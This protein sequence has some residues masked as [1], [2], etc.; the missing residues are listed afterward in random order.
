MGKYNSVAFENAFTTQYASRLAFYHTPG[1]LYDNTYAVVIAGGYP[2][3]TADKWAELAC[4]GQAREDAEA[5][6]HPI[7]QAGSLFASIKAYG[8]G[9]RPV[10]DANGGDSGIKLPRVAPGGWVQGG[11]WIEG[12]EVVDCRIVGIDL[13]TNPS[14]ITGSLE[15]IGSSNGI[16]INDCLVT[17]VTGYPI[18]GPPPVPIPGYHM[19][20]PFGIAL[21]GINYIHIK[22]T[23][24]YNSDG[25]YYC[26]YGK[27]WYIEN[28]P[29]PG[30]YVAHPY[31]YYCNW[32]YLENS[33]MS[34][35]CKSPGYGAGSAGIFL[36][37]SYDVSLNNSDFVLTDSPPGIPDD[38]GGDNETGNRRTLVK[39][40]TVGQNAGDGWLFLGNAAVTTPPGPPDVDT[41]FINVFFD[42]NG[43]ITKALVARYRTTTTNPLC[44]INCTGT[45]AVPGQFLFNGIGGT[46]LSNSPPPGSVLGPDNVFI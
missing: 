18:V 27:H 11:W 45:R 2:A 10:I 13:E 7:A 19:H 31:F 1:Q 43:D 8:S 12:I 16:V 40:C 42:R 21:T 41:M 38:L 17:D 28:S 3:A 9:A 35:Q 24:V 20:V 22:D 37:A 15:W 4:V 39:N 30:S 29:S 25:A 34:E 6:A 23:Q 5:Y 36:G 44:F 14:V 33:S 26:F 46:G 32:V